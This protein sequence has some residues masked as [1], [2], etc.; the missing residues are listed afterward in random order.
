ML[1][2]FNSWLLLDIHDKRSS[3]NKQAWGSSSGAI[4]I[5]GHRVASTLAHA[6]LQSFCTPRTSYIVGGSKVALWGMVIPPSIGNPY[7]GYKYIYITPIMGL[8]TIPYYI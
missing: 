7:N 5:F 3:E 4:N 6:E 1:F 2:L 8:M